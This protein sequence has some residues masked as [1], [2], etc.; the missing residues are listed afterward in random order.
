M[1]LDPSLQGHAGLSPLGRGTIIMGI[2][3]VTPDSFFDG[4]KF[5]DTSAALDR[6][7]QMIDDGA[8]WVDIGGE[9]SRPGASPVTL[10]EERRRV[11]PI[12]KKLAARG[13]AISVDTTKAALASEALEEGAGMINDISAFSFD[14]DMA[15]VCAGHNALCVLMHMRGT[16]RTMQSNTDYNDIVG[17]VYAFF[18]ERIAFAADHGVDRE[19]IILDPGIGFG[20][21]SSGNIK[22]IQN[23]DV[24]KQLGYPIL[25]GASRK[26]FIGSV[27]NEPAADRLAG[28]LGA[29]AVSVMNGADIL[30]VHDVKETICAVLMAEA[31]RGRAEHAPQDGRRGMRATI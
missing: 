4:G 21:S 19:R 13:V 23:I 30:R 28:S 26:S 9:S 27:T 20:K 25:I 14:P 18:K 1:S 7:M 8:D 11:I 31:M 10:E 15:S 3:N 6:A 24:F 12:V 22:L 2:L 16:P 29:A 17:E 5:I